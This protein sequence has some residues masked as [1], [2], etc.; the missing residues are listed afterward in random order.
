MHMHITAREVI[1][2]DTVHEGRSAVKFL[3]DGGASK[4][5]EGRFEIREQVVGV[6][7]ADVQPH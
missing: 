3:A 5:P 6:F 7:E 1:V 2:R 4:R